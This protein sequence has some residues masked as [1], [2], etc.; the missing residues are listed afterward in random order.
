MAEGQTVHIRTTG[1]YKYRDEWMAEV[2]LSDGR[3]MSDELV[4]GDWAV[5]WTGDGPRPADG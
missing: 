5:Y 3:N 2:T 1:P 4:L